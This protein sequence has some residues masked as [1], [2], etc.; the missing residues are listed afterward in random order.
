M[1]GTFGHSTQPGGLVLLSDAL[2]HRG[3][4]FW[5]YPT[6]TIDLGSKGIVLPA[7]NIN[8]GRVERSCCSKV[9]IKGRKAMTGKYLLLQPRR[10]Q[11]STPEGR[12]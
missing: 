7:I 9:S 3:Q 5:I 8:T 1:A 11:P 10:L 2:W 12:Y 4:V 6:I